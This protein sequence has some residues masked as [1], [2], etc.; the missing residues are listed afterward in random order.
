MERLSTNPTSSRWH[1]AGVNRGIAR[2]T[3]RHDDR[4]PGLRR[5]LI[6]S[7]KLRLGT[8]HRYIAVA[9][10]LCLYIKGSLAL[11]QK[12][13]S[14]QNTGADHFVEWN[15]WQTLGLCHD[16]CSKF[17]FGIVRG[18]ECWCSDY[19]P[20]PSQRRDDCNVQCPQYDQ[21]D[22]GNPQSGS[23]G[24]IETNRKPK[25]TAKASDG[26]TTAAS[27]MSTHASGVE[28]STASHTTPWVSVVTVD[29]P[30][31]T[32]T[33]TPPGWSAEPT[34]SPSSTSDD[35]FF[36]NAGRVAGVF[37]VLAFLIIGFILALFWFLRR[38]RQKGGPLGTDSPTPDSYGRVAV[39]GSTYEKRRSRSMSTLGL[40]SPYGPDKPPPPIISTNTGSS[41][42]PSGL[43][44]LA[45]SSGTPDRVTDQRLDPGQVWMQFENDNASRMS[46]RSLRD[47]QDY[48]RRVLRLTNPDED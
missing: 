28:T 7:T 29:G 24:Y 43:I 2:A 47:D 9:L 20:H 36:S 10:L 6:G 3:T 8:L 41:G 22:C 12:Y 18:Y 15:E 48:S 13:C 23:F 27:S 32:V 37:T 16:K 35:G 33:F 39:T 11:E 5:V 38:R 46:V 14:E 44:G 4:S 17:A 40:T 25:G 45:T 42:A 26:T 1:S 21:E 31:R 30:P 19:V 34:S